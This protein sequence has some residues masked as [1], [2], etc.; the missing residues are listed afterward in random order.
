MLF[1]MLGHERSLQ[2]WGSDT[3]KPRQMFVTQSRV[4]AGKVEEYFAR[5]VS[6][7]AAGDNSFEELAL[8]A[9][10]RQ[11]RLQE[12][13]DL[14]DLDEDINWRRDLPDR[15]SCLTDDHFPLFLTFEK[16]GLPF[17]IFLV[18]TYLHA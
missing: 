5:L 12:G 8:R 3:P 10:A 14:V 7:L 17:V 1:K 18:N 11:G 9:K 4:L 15:F 13:G 2:Y 16:V 6:S